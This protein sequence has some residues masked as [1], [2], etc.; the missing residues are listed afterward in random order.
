M[1]PSSASSAAPLYDVVIAGGGPAGLA[2]ALTLGRARKR[3][4]LCDAGAPRNAAAARVHNFVTRD[5]TPPAEMRRVAREQLGAYPKV[6]AVDSRVEGVEGDAG[7]FTVRLAT[8]D[9]R[10]R[11]VVVCTGMIDELPALSG[12][13]ELW[14][15][16]IFQCPYCHGWEVQDRPFGLLADAP[17]WLEHAPFFRGWTDDL[18]VFTGGQFEVTDAMR[19]PLT[20]AGVG[21]E[22]RPL[23]R[24]VAGDDGRLAAVE[25]ADGT[26]VTREVL[27]AKP[28]QR[29]TALVAALGLDLDEQ[30]L[31]RVDAQMRTSR[32]GVY[33]AGDLTTMLQTAVG[34]AA[35]GMTAAACVNREL[36]MELVLSGA[37]L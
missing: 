35:A 32:A 2:A 34:A 26:T 17:F 37:L 8:G 10:A 30:G 33:A 7:D 25:L 9:V 3:V 13:R 27:F 18:V 11:R 23:R 12:Y 14:G 31:V 4:L 28:P 19:A 20:A 16:S 22:E 15:R 21:L 5:G 36:T 6:A 24:L 29:Q 1:T